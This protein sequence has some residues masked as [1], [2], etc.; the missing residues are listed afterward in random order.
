MRDVASAVRAG[1]RGPEGGSRLIVVGGGKGGTGKSVVAANVS[2]LAS[3]GGRGVALVDGDLGLAN[4]HLLLGVE[5]QGTLADLL[6]PGGLARASLLQAGPGGVWL[7]PGASGVGRLAG[8]NRG[9]LRRL[10]HRLEPHVQH[11]ELLVIDLASGISPST[12]LFLQAAQEIV[13]V[14]CPEPSAVL[15]AYAVIKLVSE[16]GHAGQI[17]VVMNRV[18]DLSRGQEYGW[19]MVST[20]ERFLGRGVS[21]LGCIPEDEAVPASVHGRRPVV[22]ERPD[23]P[24]AAALRAIA[25]RLLDRAPAGRDTLAGF[26]TTAKAMMAPRRR[27]GESTCA[28]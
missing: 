12:R 11:A 13:I 6:E 21:F 1:L 27:S 5:P 19:R 4:L 18:R 9:E 10:V 16:N 8:L 25:H 7:L 26:F 3:L 23:S 24:A 14:S 17:Y 15:D 22:L 2:V 28:L 20:V